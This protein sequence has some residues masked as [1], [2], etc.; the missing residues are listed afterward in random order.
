M[1][2]NEIKTPNKDLPEAFADFFDNKISQIL[3]ETQISNNVYN[4]KNKVD[5]PNSFFMTENDI[6]ECLK[7]I[8]IKKI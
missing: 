2:L 7:N 5:H 4:G 3:N 1:S 6:L 8:K